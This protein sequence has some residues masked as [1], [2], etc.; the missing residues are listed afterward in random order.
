MPTKVCLH[1]LETYIMIIDQWQARDLKNDQT[2][3]E[4]Q[5]Y[6]NV[7]GNDN[8]IFSGALG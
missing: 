1:G 2:W 3:I 6:A 4:A 8:P 5:Q 7:R